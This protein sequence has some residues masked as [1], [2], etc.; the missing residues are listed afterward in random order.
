M[1]NKYQ[2]YDFFV[3]HSQKYKESSLLLTIFAKDLGRI[4]V[5]VSHSK[6]KAGFFQSFCLFNAQIKEPKNA[7]SLG[8]VYS[9]DNLAVYSDIS[10]LISLSKLY[11]NEILYYLLSVQHAENSLF[12]YYLHLLKNLNMDNYQYLLRFFEIK[13]LESLGYSLI[14]DIDNSG[15]EIVDGRYYNILPLDGYQLASIFTRK[16]AIKGLY[17]NALNKPFSTWS[18]DV[19]KNISKITKLNISAILGYRELKTRE[20]LK[21]YLELKS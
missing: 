4:N 5:I 17:I 6:K 3:L 20:L 16:Y 15:G 9:V 11:V 7:N 21:D 12:N 10:Y 13:L 14:S 8:S 2:R 19:L 1:Q 18:I